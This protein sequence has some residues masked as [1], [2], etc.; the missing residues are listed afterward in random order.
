MKKT[1]SWLC[2]ILWMLYL[3]FF[4]WIYANLDEKEDIQ[5]KNIENTKNDEIQEK[6][7]TEKTPTLKELFL[8]ETIS[9]EYW[10]WW[11][12]TI[13]KLSQKQE[14]EN[15]DVKN[16]LMTDL[17]QQV[18]KELQASQANEEDK[19]AYLFARTYWIT[20]NTFENANLQWIVTRKELSKML[21]SYIE[22]FTKKEL[23]FKENKCEFEDINELTDEFKISVL[24]ICW[25]WIMWVWNQK[26]NADKKITRAELV[27][28]ISRILYWNEFNNE[29]SEYYIKHLT[30][31]HSEKIISNLDYTL[32]E[33]RKNVFLILKRISVL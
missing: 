19:K 6:T 4:N 14:K 22:K 17:W 5:S 11:I 28:V 26:F 10:V 9:K 15:E 8:S 27:T 31:L 23:N 21:V 32:Q 13:E 2:V 30:K 18:N 3:S 33:K 20:T 7:P 25:Y 16:F 12:A 1:I 29:W 24:K